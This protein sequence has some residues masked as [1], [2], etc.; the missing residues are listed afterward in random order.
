MKMNDDLVSIAGRP[1]SSR[2]TVTPADF[3][4]VYGIG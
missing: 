3:F 2:S 1:H 4:A